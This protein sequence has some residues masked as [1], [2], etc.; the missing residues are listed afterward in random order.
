MTSKTKRAT[1]YLEPELHRTLR[2][3]AVQ[4]ERSI[5]DLVNQAI[6]DSLFEDSEDLAAF[7]ARDAEPDLDFEQVL[8]D[9]KKR[10]KI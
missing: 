5:S 9:L 4:M 1:I 8:L 10:G 6:R 3:K 2:L 7:E